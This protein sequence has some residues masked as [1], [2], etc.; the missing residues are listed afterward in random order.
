MSLSKGEHLKVCVGDMIDARFKVIGELG[1]GNFSK[2]YCCYDVTGQ[3]GVKVALV[4][5]KIIKRDYR[6]DAY[7][8]RNM[9]E[10]LN[11]KHLGGLAVCRMF[12]FFEWRRCPVFVMSIHGPSLRTRRL[13]Y[14]NGVVTRAKLVELSYSLLTTF[15]HIHFDCRIVHT[16]VKPDNILLADLNPPK[17]SLGTKWVVCDFGSASLWRMDRLDADLIST[18]PY[19]A[20]EVVLGNPWFYA[21]DVWSIGCILYEVATGQRL[22]DVCDDV[23]HLQLMEKRLGPL[24]AL[25]KKNSKYSGRYFTESGEFLHTSE[26]IRAGRVMNTRKLADVFHDDPELYDLIAS[27]LI[28][29]PLQR[30][31]TK[32]ALEHPIF[33]NHF[34]KK[35]DLIENG[36]ENGDENSI[37]FP[38]AVPPNNNETVYVA[39]ARQVGGLSWVEKKTLAKRGSLTSATHTS[40]NTGLNPHPPAHQMKIAA[41]IPESGKTTQSPCVYKSCTE[42]SHASFSDSLHPFAETDVKPVPNAGHLPGCSLTSQRNNMFCKVDRLPV[43]CALAIDVQEKQ[44]GSLQ[45]TM[46]S[47]EFPAPVSADNKSEGT[48]VVRTPA[49]PSLPLMYPSEEV[50]FSVETASE[51]TDPHLNPHKQPLEASGALVGTKLVETSPTEEMTSAR[52]PLEPLTHSTDLNAETILCPSKPLSSASEVVNC[53]ALSPEAKESSTGMMLHSSALHVLRIQKGNSASSS[54]S[55]RSSHITASK[56]E[57]P[58]FFSPSPQLPTPA[59]A[60]KLLTATPS[61]PFTMAETKPLPQTVEAGDSMN[62]LSIHSYSFPITQGAVIQRVKGGMTVRGATSKLKPQPRPPSTAQ[63]ISHSNQSVAGSSL[64]RFPLTTVACPPSAHM[65]CVRLR[66]RSDTSMNVPKT[67]QVVRGRTYRSNSPKIPFY[68]DNYSQKNVSSVAGGGVL[69]NACAIPPQ[70]SFIFDESTAASSVVLPK[71]SAFSSTKRGDSGVPPIG[72]SSAEVRPTYRQVIQRNVVTAGRAG[73]GGKVPFRQEL[74]NPSVA[75]RNTHSTAGAYGNSAGSG[76][77]TGV[78][79]CKRDTGEMG[80]FV[81]AP[82]S[83]LRVPHNARRFRA[84]R[85]PE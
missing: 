5:L 78:D 18:R 32:E 62:G 52:S 63:S 35:T 48:S 80:F 65:D 75:S 49:E 74:K 14:Q 60:V 2:V 73:V 6:E 22:F 17:Y 8:E 82:P 59:A 23:T 1:A 53:P 39:G 45:G 30:A 33:Y 51:Y 10:I 31:T 71:F 24:P 20:P 15:R 40:Y 50:S 13:G 79:R 69:T 37:G 9:L 81:E 26:L 85:A 68:R 43:A 34:S 47:C 25:F 55:R 42:E 44:E 83:E 38:R 64:R 28:Y 77:T 27:M 19:R 3:R 12:E 84:V 41:G 58:S 54:I 61:P 72:R 66:R 11:E 76:V 56:L 16:D 29:D 7:C 67:C 57:K 46:R 4:A 70:P 21:A 36:L